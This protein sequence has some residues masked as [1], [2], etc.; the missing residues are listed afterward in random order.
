VDLYEKNYHNYNALDLAIGSNNKPAVELLL[1]KGNKWFSSDNEGINPYYVASAFGRKELFQL[2]EKKNI[3]GKPKRR[4]DELATSVSIKL[5][6][7]DFYTGIS[8]SGKEPLLNAGFT[9][10]F[11]SKVWYTRVLMKAGEDIYF[12]Y[13]DK[14]SIVYGGLFKDFTLME[15]L[16]GNK[17]FLTS[18]LMGAYTFGNKL[19]GTRMTPENKFRVI[20][21]AGIKLQINHIQAFAGIEYMK[22]VFFKAGPIWLR[23]GVSYN[24]YM[25]KVR[26]PRK[27][28]KWY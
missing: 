24:F 20:P 26:A 2:L 27:V 19:K 1:N 18:S 12:Q 15:N 3:P 11:D 10:G 8:L 21:S 16:R 25:S 23:T 5:N 22:S 9:A 7:H 6:T 13:L 4:F 28:I 17:L 14:S